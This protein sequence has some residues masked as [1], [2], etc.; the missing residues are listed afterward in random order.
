MAKKTKVVR[1]KMGKAVSP[2]GDGW[3]LLHAYPVAGQPEMVEYTFVQD[4]D[5]Q[6]RVLLTQ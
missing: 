2:P 6:G 5:E 4:V 1:A 3:E